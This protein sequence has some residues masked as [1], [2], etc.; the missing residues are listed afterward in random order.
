MHRLPNIRS[1]APPGFAISKPVL[2]VLMSATSNSALLKSAYYGDTL[3]RGRWAGNLSQRL[4]GP[5]GGTDSLFHHQTSTCTENGKFQAVNFELVPGSK[6]FHLL[7]GT[8]LQMFISQLLF[9]QFFFLIYLK[10]EAVAI[11]NIR[12]GV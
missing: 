4:P 10:S 2:M 8:L 5:E 6:R 7:P 1:L 11:F 12:K 3:I 9:A